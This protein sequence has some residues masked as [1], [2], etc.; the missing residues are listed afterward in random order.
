LPFQRRGESRLICKLCCRKTCLISVR[1]ET[2]LGCVAADRAVVEGP[3]GDNYKLARPRSQG[4]KM[5]AV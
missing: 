1:S 5:L 4:A 2:T 3:N